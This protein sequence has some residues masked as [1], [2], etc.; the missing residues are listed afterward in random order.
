MRMYSIGKFEFVVHCVSLHPFQS[1]WAPTQTGDRPCRG[2]WPC[3]RPLKL[4]GSLLALTFHSLM[5]YWHSQR[6]QCKTSSSFPHCGRNAGCVVQWHDGQK[7]AVP[8]LK[9]LLCLKEGSVVFHLCVVSIL[10]MRMLS[11]PAFCRLAVKTELQPRGFSGMAH[12]FLFWL[13]EKMG[14]SPE[15]AFHDQSSQLITWSKGI[16]LWSEGSWHCAFSISVC[17]FIRLVMMLTSYT[18]IP[19]FF[20]SLISQFV[21]NNSVHCQ[22]TKF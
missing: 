18:D 17:L 16:F 2:Q 10:Q 22:M 9:P 13:L 1:A 6:Y 11:L 20:N 8:G 21:G 15:A 4:L 14:L 19:F 5:S 12:C 7:G 3:P